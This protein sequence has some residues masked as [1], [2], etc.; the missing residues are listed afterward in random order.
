MMSKNERDSHE[1]ADRELD[2]TSRYSQLRELFAQ[3]TEIDSAKLPQWLQ[4]NV[5]DEDMRAALTRLLAADQR[6]SGF[7]ETPAT[8]RAAHLE[9]SLPKPEGLLGSTVG[10][11]KLERLLGNGGMAAVFL[12]TRVDGDF[13]QQV[14]VK[15][16]RR[17]LFSEIE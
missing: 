4:F 15:L 5:S 10:A 17:G 16:L 1:A 14:A 8:Q 12:G 9:D 11:F 7:F 2:N 3:A 13:D 6:E